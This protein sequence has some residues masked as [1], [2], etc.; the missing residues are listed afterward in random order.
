VYRPVEETVPTVEFPPATPFTDQ[1]TLELKL[2]VPLTAALHWLLCPT[3][4]ALRAQDTLTDVIV[5][6]G[7]GAVVLVVEPGLFPPQLVSAK[8]AQMGTERLRRDA[9]DWRP[10]RVRI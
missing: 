2:P 10:G 7:G 1:V 5:D 9:I 3:G 8:S 4:A 6:D